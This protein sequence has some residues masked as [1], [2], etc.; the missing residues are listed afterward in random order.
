MLRTQANIHTASGQDI[1]GTLVNTI[2]GLNIYDV[3][4]DNIGSYA[5]I[6][7]NVSLTTGASSSSLF[8]NNIYLNNS[9][10]VYE[11]TTTTSSSGIAI[12]ISQDDT[13]WQTL[14][15]MFPIVAQTGKRTASL[16]LSLKAFKYIR[17]L[18][19]ATTTY[20]NVICSLYSS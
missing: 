9:V 1:S 17:I 3:G 6:I 8:I 7:N 2:R 18:N 16:I 5:N 19:I 11:D 12:Q 10:I 13:V 15:S 20:N 4:N 14:A